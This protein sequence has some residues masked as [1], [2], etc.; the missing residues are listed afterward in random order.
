MNMSKIQ[1]LFRSKLPAGKAGTYLAAT[2]TV[3]VLA[4]A[5]SGLLTPANAHPDRNEG[6]LK[7]LRD[8]YQK[9]Q[10]YE[11]EQLEVG[12][13][14]AT[15]YGGDIDA[16]MALWADDCTLTSGTTVYSGK[17]A[18]RAV[19]AA[20]GGFTHYWVGLTPAFKLTADIHGDTADLSFQ[21]D[22]VDPHVTPPTVQAEKLLYGTVKRVRGQWLFWHMTSAG[23]SLEP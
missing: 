4:A 3:A 12:F 21:C 2:T 7:E 14:S 19:F 9:A 8:I 1:R 10:L 22:F 13:H 15:S 20:G 6:D 5:A 23:A 11:V 18:V 17:D 16:L